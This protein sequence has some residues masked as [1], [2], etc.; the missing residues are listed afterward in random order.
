MT[1]KQLSMHES[2]NTERY[3]GPHGDN[4][5]SSMHRTNRHPPPTPTPTQLRARCRSP[6][7]ISRGTP[8][9]AET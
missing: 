5:H 2:R 6:A 7:S 3:P 4:E 8:P 1:Q 9:P